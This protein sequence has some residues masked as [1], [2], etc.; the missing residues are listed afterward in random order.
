MQRYSHAMVC[1]L[2]ASGV[3]AAQLLRREGT[4]VIAVDEF[5]TAATQRAA[6]TLRAAGCRVE[7]GCDAPPEVIVD[8]AIVSPGLALHSPLLVALQKRGIPLLSEMELG[9]SR[10]AGHTVAVTG[11]NG[12]SSVV[13]ALAD[14]FAAAGHKAV[15]CGNYGLPVCQA[16]MTDPEWLVIEA[17]SFQLETC[18]GFR[19]DIG[20][21]LNIFPN[22][23][24]RHGT[25]ETYARLKARLLSRQRAG[26]AAWVP[27]EWAA[28]LRAWS[29]GQ[30]TWHTFG[31][32]PQE[33]VHYAAHQLVARDGRAYNIAGSYF[34][35]EVLGANAAALLGAAQAAGLQPALVAQTLMDFQPLPHRA[36]LVGEVN[37]VRYV[38][39]SKATNLSAMLAAIRMQ[40]GAVILIAGG[41]PK[42]K[43]FTAA[44]P[45]LRERVRRVFL[46]GEAAAAMQAAWGAHV[47]CTDCHTLAQAVAAARQTAR[48]GETV[49]LA[50]AC[51]SYDQF[52]AYPERGEAFRKYVTEKD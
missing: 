33:E 45:L 12:K 51:T 21:V 17:S 22:H 44:V 20:I 35:N 8:V 11:S 13:K 39:D 15:P 25:L 47:P 19:P 4:T 28:S 50:P 32:T 48:P 40:R 52:R 30:G 27:P 5:D 49:L 18:A 43:D 24:D 3:A 9:W 1:G 37:G 2:G 26:D 10:H 16:V 41:R 34:D 29:Q 36:E 6:E 42:E 23:L 38:N 7:L 31:T 46:I 14:C